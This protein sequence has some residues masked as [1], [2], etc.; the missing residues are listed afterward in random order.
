MDAKPSYA[1][2]RK[3]RRRKGLTAFSTGGSIAGI[4]KFFPIIFIGYAPYVIVLG[5]TVSAV[6][7]SLFLIGLIRPRD[8]AGWNEH[9][10]RLIRSDE[11][12]SIHEFLVVHLG[13]DISTV[14]QMRA[15]HK[16][17]PQM[18]FVVERKNYKRNADVPSLAFTETVGFFEII[19]LKQGAVNEIEDRKLDGRG[20]D[21]TRHVTRSRGKPQAYYVG[22]VI[23]AD[24][25]SK[26]RALKFLVEQMNNVVRKRQTS[27]FYARA[28]TPDGLRI[29]KKYNFKSVESGSSPEIGQVCKVF[30]T[31]AEPNRRA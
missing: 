1:R 26:G 3:A 16:I 29:A 5:L 20:L 9:V 30:W 7:A 24:F 12:K 15:W 4:S 13:P 17:N 19:P 10:F 2:V 31:P 14:D 18:F 11:L 27:I 22:S 23:G 28:V 25:S 21:A 6:G 8:L